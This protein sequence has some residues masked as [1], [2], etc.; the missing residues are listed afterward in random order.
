MSV[1]IGEENLTNLPPTKHWL[2]FTDLDGTLLDHDNY[3]FEP[4]LQALNRLREQQVPVIL[5]SS[6][7]LAELHALASQL[8]LPSPLVSENGS[9][10]A[11]PEHDDYRIEYT[12]ES[13][14]TITNTL[15]RL[16]E[17]YQ[18]QFE[19]FHD[20]DAQGVADKTGLPLEAAALAGQ[21]QGSEPLL[22]DDTSAK[23]ED[24]RQ[25]LALAGLVL[26]KGGRFWHVMGQTDKVKAMQQVASTYAQQRGH[27]SFV[28]A[29]GDGPNDK[30]MLS[31]A[32]I[33]IKVK[34]PHSDNFDLPL[35]QGQVQFFTNET[36]PRGWNQTLLSLID[37]TN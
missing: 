19:G 4:A 27:Y 32:D 17:Q 16:R 26:K 11:T 2:V 10:I 12:G 3:S 20:W 37:K 34:N 14:Q 24:F 7:T 25:Q 33:A 15:D 35:K 5:N 21:R 9:I 36:G 1:I 22:W 18:Y 13:Y 29:L 30:E 6:K 28:I 23:L 31:A 8:D